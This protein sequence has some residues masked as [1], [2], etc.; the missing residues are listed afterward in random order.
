[1]N[2]LLIVVSTLLILFIIIIILLPSNKQSDNGA[3]KS[4]QRITSVTSTTFI[5]GIDSISTTNYA[6]RILKYYYYIPTVVFASKDQPQ[7]ALVMIPYLSGLGEHFVLP[8]FKEFAKKEGFVIISPSFQYDKEN[9]ETQTSYQ[10]PAAWSGNALL[11]IISQFEEKND[12][13]ISGLYLFGFS[14]GAQFALRF[15]FWNP[16]LC[17]ACAAHGSGGTVIPDKKIDVKFFVS[18]G[19]NDIQRIEKAKTFYEVAQKYGIEVTYR[20]YDTG[21]AMVPE[22]VKETLDFFKRLEF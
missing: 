6:N 7:R 11:K 3:N 21:H 9:W 10:Y 18:V 8:E 19:K 22:Q 20:E 17:V 2:R 16:E 12:L 14:A 15:C 1:M 13:Q 4:G 5:D